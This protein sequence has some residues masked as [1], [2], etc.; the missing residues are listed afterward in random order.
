MRLDL[1]DRFSEELVKI[2]HTVDVLAAESFAGRGNLILITHGAAF[3]VVATF[4]IFRNAM[5]RNYGRRF[6][7]FAQTSEHGLL[8]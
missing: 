1:I 4:L 3:F 5:I 8:G 6:P 2:P 7:N